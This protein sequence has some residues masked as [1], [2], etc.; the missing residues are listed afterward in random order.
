M[1]K[2]CLLEH[3]ESDLHFLSAHLFMPSIT[4]LPSVC[5]CAH[6]QGLCLPHTHTCGRPVVPMHVRRK[7]GGETIQKKVRPRPSSPLSGLF[8]GLL[9]QLK[10]HFGPPILWRYVMREP[11]KLVVPSTAISGEIPPLDQRRGNA[12]LVP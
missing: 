3:K 6:V 11:K 5:L 4:A 2:I 10:C 8:S 1:F 7:R 9:E 12:G